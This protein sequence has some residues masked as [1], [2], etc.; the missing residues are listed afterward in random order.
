MTL[1]YVDSVVD[2]VAHLHG[3][4]VLVVNED[5]GAAVGSQHVDIGRQVVSALE[6]S[7][8]VSDRGPSI[9]SPWQRPPPS[10]TRTDPES[11]LGAV[12]EPP[13]GGFPF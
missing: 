11:P 10:W 7:P 2:P 12:T 9:R 3:L 6:H 13:G 1:I 4:P 8:A 5:S